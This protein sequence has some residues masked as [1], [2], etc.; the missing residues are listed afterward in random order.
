MNLRTESKRDAT[1]LIC[2]APGHDSNKSNEQWESFAED[3]VYDARYSL[4]SLTFVYWNKAGQESTY[5]NKNA[6]QKQADIYP[7]YH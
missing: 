2:E 1:K 5:G 6:G 4:W 7:N 3:K